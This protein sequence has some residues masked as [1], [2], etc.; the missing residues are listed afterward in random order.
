MDLEKHPYYGATLETEKQRIED[1]GTGR[2]I[3]L[4]RFQY[5]YAPTNHSIP[6]KAEVITEAYIKFLEKT[7]WADALEMVLEPRL[8]YEKGGFSVFATCQAKRGNLIPTEHLDK[9]RPI[10][11][12]LQ[13]KV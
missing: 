6:T 8:V 13:G 12:I 5:K 3:I 4:R 2:P 9:M 1:G 11:D 7:L 10:Q